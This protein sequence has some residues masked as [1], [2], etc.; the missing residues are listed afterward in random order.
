M[1]QTFR[2]IPVTTKTIIANTGWHL[3]IENIYNNFPITPYVI[4]KKKRGRK[5]RED[6]GDTSKKPAEGSIIS[7]KYKNSIKGVDSKNKTKKREV[8]DEGRANKKKYF[9]NSVTLEMMLDKKINFKLSKNGSIQLTGCKKTEHAEKCV[10][11]VW[12]YIKDLQN[13]DIQVCENYNKIKKGFTVVFTNGLRN[14]NFFL[15]FRIDRIALNNYINNFTTYKSR[16]NWEQHYAG[17][18]I[19]FPVNLDECDVKLDTLSLTSRKNLREDTWKKG[20]I[21]YSDYYKNMNE[22]DKKKEDIKRKKKEEENS[23]FVFC[24]GKVILSGKYLETTEKNY[25][26]FLEVMKEA[27]DIIEEKLDLC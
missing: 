27:K 15:D 20:K 21:M 4:V 19:K 16:F 17:V 8:V 5:K 24:S 26:A 13:R 12:Q 18:N 11:Y 6:E 25:Y 9:R 7:M 14:V 2:S 10:K 1:H 22:E 23:F 3:I